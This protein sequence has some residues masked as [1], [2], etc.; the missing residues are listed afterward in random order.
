MTT[1]TTEIIS[2]CFGSIQ[3]YVPKTK[4]DIDRA[5]KLLTMLEE[6]LNESKSVIVPVEIKPCRCSQTTPQD[7]RQ[8][9]PLSHSE[10]L[11]RID[12]YV[13]ALRA[14]DSFLAQVFSAPGD[15]S[16]GASLHTGGRTRTSPCCQCDMCVSYRKQAEIMKQMDRTQLEQYGTDLMKVCFK[17]EDTYDQFLNYMGFISNTE[18]IEAKPISAGE[19]EDLDV[20]TSTLSENAPERIL[21]DFFIPKFKWDKTKEKSY[22][23]IFF[24]EHEDGRVMISYMHSRIFTTKAV[25]LALPYPIPRNY[26]L[27]HSLGNNKRTAF[28]FYREYLAKEAASHELV[29]WKDK[30][31][32]DKGIFED[33]QLHEAENKDE[34]EIMSEAAREAEEKRMEKLRK[35]A[36]VNAGRWKE[37]DMSP[38][39]K[40]LRKNIVLKASMGVGAD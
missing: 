38:R 10:E 13:N 11:H 34:D 27:L 24:F 26:P 12:N 22:R 15:V 19:R 2:L 39:T 4:E 28:R 9:Q 21:S 7:E 29:R 1:E 40:E 23:T 8:R 5:R 17:N 14:G 6:D 37:S 33:N 20:K 35:A 25:V 16:T 18:Q 36:E 32:Q 3:I 31:N 30:N